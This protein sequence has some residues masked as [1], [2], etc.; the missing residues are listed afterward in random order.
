M[1]VE[2]KSHVYLL[3]LL[4]LVLIPLKKSFAISDFNI[5]DVGDGR[6]YIM[7][8][9]TENNIKDQFRAS[10]LLILLY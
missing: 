5:D 10:R 2:G 1:F 7:P 8:K 9:S 6:V 4:F 3:L